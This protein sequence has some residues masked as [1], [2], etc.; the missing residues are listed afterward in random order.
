MTITERPLVDQE[1]IDVVEK[2]SVIRFTVMRALYEN[3]R[4]NPHGGGLTM[5]QLQ[6]ASNVA[7]DD[8]AFSSWY[9]RTKKLMLMNDRSIVDIT[10][11]GIDFFEKQLDKYREQSLS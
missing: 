4:A 7:Q 1:L 6:N 3:K 2:E 5:L 10:L 9:L 11:E 8:L